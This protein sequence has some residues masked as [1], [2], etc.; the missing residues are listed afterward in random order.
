MDKLPFASLF[1]FGDWIVDLLL[2]KTEGNKKQ[3][4]KVTEKKVERPT[5]LTEKMNSGIPKDVIDRSY[6][7]DLTHVGKN[8]MWRQSAKKEKN[9]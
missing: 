2:K 5:S 9:T 1:E 4:E 8:G 6:E 3:T 7:V